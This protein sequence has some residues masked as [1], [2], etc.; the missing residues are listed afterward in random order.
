MPAPVAGPGFLKML[1]PACRGRAG[2]EI[3]GRGR[4]GPGKQVN[5]GRRAGPGFFRMPIPACR[6]RAGLKKMAGIPANRGYD[7][8]RS[9]PNGPSLA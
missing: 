3:A 9:I 2:I 1:F 4:A 6:G 5:P 7:R 8:A